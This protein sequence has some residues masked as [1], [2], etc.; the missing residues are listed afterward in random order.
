VKKFLLNWQK[1]F[2]LSYKKKREKKRGEK[3]E[4]AHFLT[5]L[6][7]RGCKESRL[8]KLTALMTSILYES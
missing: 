5:P 3:E 2:S 4:Q 6:Q 7:A 8:D 1:E